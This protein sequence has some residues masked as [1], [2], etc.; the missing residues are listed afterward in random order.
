MS[1]CSDEAVDGTS[2]LQRRAPFFAVKRGQ[3]A[4]R[5][6]EVITTVPGILCSVTVGA[7]IAPLTGS[8]W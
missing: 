4:P 2:A 6:T 1:T 8:P 7:P 3:T 5:S